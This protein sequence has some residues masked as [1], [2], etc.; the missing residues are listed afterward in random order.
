MTSESNNK[1]AEITNHKYGLWTA[2]I[3]SFT[4]IIIAL[5]NTCGG[6]KHSE[7][8]K[9]SE[10]VSVE[11]N[12]SNGGTNNKQELISQTYENDKSQ[13]WADPVCDYSKNCNGLVRLIRNSGKGTFFD[14]EGKREI[15]LQVGD[16]NVGAAIY[17]WNTTNMVSTN[18]SVNFQ[19]R[20]ISETEYQIIGTIFGSTGSKSETT[21]IHAPTGTKLRFSFG[22]GCVIRNNGKQ[23]EPCRQTPTTGTSENLTMQIGT[24][25][26]DKN[27]GY[28]DQGQVS[29]VYEIIK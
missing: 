15:T 20:H 12:K 8:P 9:Q 29:L 26:P 19:L 21:L 13:A 17:F 11:T 22:S 18:V 7:I 24:V 25:N 23:Q 10:V 1:P 2:I 14:T 5:I 16:I 27:R 6:V 3:G 28:E 4:A